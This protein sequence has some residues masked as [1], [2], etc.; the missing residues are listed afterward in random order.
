[1]YEYKLKLVREK[2]DGYD[3]D[4]VAGRPSEAYAVL[5]PLLSDLASEAVY[6]MCLSADNAVIGVHRVSEGT[7]DRSI[8]HPRDVF[9]PALLSPTKKIILAHNHPSG[10]L[11]ISDVDKEVT[12]NIVLAGRLL[13][14]PLSDHLIVGSFDAGFVSIRASGEVP[15]DVDDFE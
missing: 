9:A 10:D 1:M 8:C 4:L 15:F 13:G 5:K 11:T 6:V 3:T 12:R 2:V 7:L 14:I